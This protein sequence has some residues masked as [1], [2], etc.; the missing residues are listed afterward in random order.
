MSFQSAFNLSSFLEIK[1][2]LQNARSASVP[3]S[4]NILTTTSNEPKCSE[5]NEE[6]KLYCETC[7]ELICFRCALKS[8]KHHSHDY[9]DPDTAYENHKKEVTSL[10]MPIEEEIAALKEALTEFEACHRE[11]SK[12]Q[13]TIEE[14]IHTSFRQLRL[15]LDTR[16]SELIKQLQRMTEEKQCR[17]A[18]QR[19]QV[20]TLLAQQS[21][22]R[23]FLWDSL[24]RG[25]I[26]DVLLQ[27]A[28]AVRQFK[29][30]VAPLQT[31]CLEPVA[32]A[33]LT[34]KAPTDL[35]VD[36]K[37]FGFILSKSSPDPKKCY[38]MVSSA[39]M[40]EN[41]TA[42][43]QA[44]N[45]KGEICIEPFEFLECEL[46]SNLTGDSTKCS[47]QRTERGQ[48]YIN[49][50]PTVKGM[51]QLHIKAEGQGI[52]GNPF[53][54]AVTAPINKELGSPIKTIK[55]V[56]GSWGI[57]L[58]QKEE[59]IVTEYNAHCISLFSSSGE[60][61]LSFG[62]QGSGPGELQ[63]PLGVAV[64]EKG[65]IIVAD[66]GNNC[67]QKYSP[68]GH[69]L[70]KAGVKRQ[71]HLKFLSITD[72]A[73]CPTREVVYVVDRGSNCVHV[74]NDDLTFS[75]VIGKKGRGKGQ[76]NSPLGIACDRT[77]K[78]YVV[79]SGNHRIQVFTTEGK[80]SRMFGRH[81]YADG[82]LEWPCYIA[83]DT[84]NR[85]Y[86]GQQGMHRVSIFSSQ[87]HFLTSFGNGLETFD[88]IRGIAVD[89]TGV[90]Y[91]CDY[92]NRIQLF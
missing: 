76:F 63:G 75:S 2:S 55:G 7:E 88:S 84:Q 87:G 26:E 38:A 73:F 28:T 45:I 21:S 79:D 44:I 83:V 53:N 60:K 1:D 68:T 15:V 31:V 32:Q 19:M 52:R 89:S 13:G 34:F 82:E 33:D 72:V 57:A 56:L 90:V 6:C 74:L 77:G 67:I 92:N 62:R 66:S 85:V 29:E 49:Y 78:L 5:H 20:E 4:I 70:A 8:G 16:E 27:K 9:N 18:G 46:V 11:I 50:Q 36:C 3:D 23:Q 41:C 22:R 30:Q 39:T 12:Q 17:L 81:G 64:D 40:G 54:I 24:G 91:I 37:N 43:L 71:G 47:V 65:N 42:I 51:H 86:V 58:N 35:L 48:Y 59:V 69:F 80:F 61:L 10:T 14:R 25:K